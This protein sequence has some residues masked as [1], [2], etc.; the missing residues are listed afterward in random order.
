[1][2]AIRTSYPVTVTNIPE[3]EWTQVVVLANP[4]DKANAIVNFDGVF[5]VL[6]P[7]ENG[8]SLE[9][10]MTASGPSKKQLATPLYTLFKVVGRGLDD[11]QSYIEE[12]RY[13]SPQSIAFN[14]TQNSIVEFL[15][16]AS[17]DVNQ[18]ASLSLEV[19]SNRALNAITSNN[20]SFNAIFLN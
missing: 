13:N 17:S 6:A 16:T 7:F 4:S 3:G 19:R 15:L 11:D 14:V 10:R 8:D 18:F 1:M 12:S 5:R 9:F 20:L 2:T